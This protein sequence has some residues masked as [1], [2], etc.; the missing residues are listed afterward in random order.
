[1]A[2]TTRGLPVPVPA[3]LSNDT[4]IVNTAT[5]SAIFRVVLLL[6]GCAL[7]LY[8]W[9]AHRV[10][11]SHQLSARRDQAS[12]QRAIQLQPKDAANYDLLGQYFMWE[13]QDARAAAAQF[14]QAVHLNPYDSATWMH[15]AQ[16]YNVLGAESEQAQAI[17]NAIAVDPTTPEIAWNAANF[18]LIQG[19]T[20]EA[21]DQLG[22]VIRNDSGMAE[23][24]LDLGWRASGDVE[25]IERRLP[26]DPA[27][28]LNFI[29]VLIHRE[30]WAAASHAWESLLAMNRDFDPRSALFYIDVL[31]TKRDVAG[32]QNAWHQLVQRSDV[33]K[34]YVRPGNLVVNTN[35]DCDMLNAGFDWHYSAIPNV[36]V[37]LDS[38]QSY[39]ANQALLVTYFG[40]S[41]DTGMRQ[42][43]P[44]KPGAAYVVSAWVK[45][46][47]LRSA[48]GPRLAVSDAY[49]N[50]EY[51]HSDETLGTTPW[52]EVQTAF[53]AGP[54]TNLVLLQ[55]S[56]HPGDTRIQ[57]RF[58]ADAVRL[59][60]RAGS[61][62]EF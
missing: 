38:T 54:D 13:V 31:L 15:L 16:A 58:C 6:I 28:Y 27:I 9:C 25:A 37:M 41:A 53:T 42:Y 59:S 40:V 44:V 5:S 52:H 33:L 45:S 30:Q 2:R 11:Q 36:S 61:S 29:K 8:S 4:V 48:N 39:Q 50:V 22:I 20:A 24:A 17:R 12:L 47:E 43:V 18:F 49:Q 14:Q 26:S 35:F 23:A 51:A 60:Q 46:E 1:M 56:R 55:F 3:S 62:S 57:G 34:P 10:Y 7:V 21:L 32:A 19:N